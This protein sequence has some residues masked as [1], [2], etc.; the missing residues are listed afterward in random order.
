MASPKAR[1]LLSTHIHF[2]TLC[3]A[4]SLL[5]ATSSVKAADPQYSATLLGP[6]GLNTTPSARMNAPG[7]I[8]AGVSTLDPYTH[9]YINVQ[10]ASPL[11]LTLRQSAQTSSLK[12]SADKLLPGLD[13]KLRLLEENA[14]R[15]SIALGLQSAFGHKRM[16]GEY[17]ALSKRYQ[18]FDFTGGV[19]WGRYAGKGHLKNPL[20]LLGNHFDQNRPND[21]EMPGGP[22]D[23]FTG[24]K[25]GFFGGVEYFTPVNGLSLKL[26]YNPDAYTA[27]Q[28]ATPNFTA[29]AHWGASL[30][31]TQENIAAS[32]GIQGTNKII[33]RLS[34]H[35]T[36]DIWPFHDKEYQEPRPFPQKR[37]AIPAQ[38]QQI[39]QSAE[40]ENITLHDITE[41]NG[42]ITAQLVL[43]QNN[44]ATK[45]IGR[46]ARHLA[47]YASPETELINLQPVILGLRGPEIRLMRTDLERA[48][49]N[50]QGSPEEIWANMELHPQ[51]ETRPFQTQEKRK[52][53]HFTLENAFSLSEED[54]GILYRT[55]LLADIEETGFLGFLN[56]GAALRL[57]LLDN[58]DQLDTIRTPA[59]FPVRSDINS[60]TRNPLGLETAYTNWMLNPRKNL[61]AEIT[62]GYLEEMYAGL[63]G[64][65]LYR[66]ASSRFALGAEIWQAF[67]RD[68]LSPLHLALN[69]DHI[70]SGHINAWYDIPSHD[71]TLGAKFGRYLAEDIGAT[72]SLDKTFQNGASLGT[73]LTVTNQSDPDTYGGTTHT[74]H[75]IKLSLP[76]GSIKHIPNGSR[77]NVKTEAFGRDTG[78]YINAP[79]PLYKQTQNFTTNHLAK[80]WSTI[81][82]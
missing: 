4:A 3:V 39:E 38:P 74:Q 80:N 70:L 55:S 25:I 73:Y 21:G 28:N 8:S 76:L 37:S 44:E 23:W 31:Y 19:G 27:E 47:T 48:L 2:C 5:Y 20:G 35:A 77:L 22:N 75:G 14:H 57:Q 45:D 26:D 18:N 12:N 52:T 41:E 9:A 56:N 68:P 33:A 49:K 10:M 65:I 60:F 43:D 67:H 6:L 53:L 62:A 11:A 66:P 50:R 29:P 40:K 51:E 46:A 59:P 1:R 36:P 7:K 58:L 79:L 78:Q 32:L 42:T 61:Y 15:P 63:G 72:L 82:D 34:V 81:L 16:A 54:S 13:I 24:E 17:I 71:I 69:G 64:E 30:N